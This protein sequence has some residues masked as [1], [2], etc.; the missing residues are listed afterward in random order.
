MKPIKLDNRI[1]Y[2]RYYKSAD[3]QIIHHFNVIDRH[4]IKETKK[5]VKETSNDPCI[6]LI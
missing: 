1:R 4:P 3:T 6:W 2:Q 5:N